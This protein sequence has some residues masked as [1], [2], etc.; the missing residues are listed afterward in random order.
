MIY[1]SKGSTFIDSS[2]VLRYVWSIQGG[3]MV[4]ADTKYHMKYEL[5]SGRGRMTGRSMDIART[6][7]MQPELSYRDVAKKFNISRQ[8]V[9]QIVRRLGV[10][11]KRKLYEGAVTTGQDEG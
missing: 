1:G 8:R 7:L 5:L 2:C 6:I 3:M 10:A 11:R 4:Q 9:G